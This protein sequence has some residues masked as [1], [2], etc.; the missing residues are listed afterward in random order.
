MALKDVNLVSL[1]RSTFGQMARYLDSF[2]DAAPTRVA[3]MGNPYPELVIMMNSFGH[4]MA[5]EY[6]DTLMHP[7]CPREAMT[8]IAIELIQTMLCA[9][10]HAHMKGYSLLIVT[11][12]GL[13]QWPHQVQTMVILIQKAL[14]RLGLMYSV[15]GPNIRV[16][17]DYRPEHWRW[18]AVLAWLSKT[19][20]SFP[21]F[22]GFDL[23]LDDVT[24]WDW[25]ALMDEMLLSSR[26]L[27]SVSFAAIEHIILKI[28]CYGMEKGNY[29]GK[30]CRVL[31]HEIAQVPDRI[32][33]YRDHPTTGYEMDTFPRAEIG[34]GITEQNTPTGLCTILTRCNRALDEMEP[35]ATRDDALRRLKTSWR[36]WPQGKLSDLE[37]L[38]PAWELENIQNA[39]LVSD[40]QLS[41]YANVLFKLA[42]ID[43]V[44]LYLA[45]GHEAFL[46]GPTS[47]F[48]ERWRD[49]TMLEQYTLFC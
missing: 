31:F 28:K 33:T 38:G 22:E 11:P 8:D 37:A 20:Q 36:D 29:L 46:R 10:K 3:L 21:G 5:S 2:V 15:T 23:T 19:V 18:P 9:Y 49:I 26:V 41:R 14:S 39:Y 7:E 1:L 35:N 6:Y 16:D 30:P 47:L 45:F 17:K 34:P 43:L 24:F 13:S 25:S 40:A 27:D 4:L 44:A 48:R 12:P 32:Y 42:P